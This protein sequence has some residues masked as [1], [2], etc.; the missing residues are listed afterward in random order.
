[1]V[2]KRIRKKR[3][4][5]KQEHTSLPN[6]NEKYTPV[7]KKCKA[8]SQNYQIMQY[9]IGHES[10]TQKEAAQMFDCW[11]LPARIF[12]LRKK[13]AIIRTEDIPT[14]SKCASSSYARY[15]LEGVTK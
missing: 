3:A 14:I 9:L 2:S 4:L 11:R 8:D 1:M 6:Y 15:Y 7:L 13:G 10:I 12:E 5:M